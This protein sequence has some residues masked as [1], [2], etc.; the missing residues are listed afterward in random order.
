M[1]GTRKRPE[2]DLPISIAINKTPDLQ[3]LFYCCHRILFRVTTVSS[4]EQVMEPGKLIQVPFLKV[5][6]DLQFRS[7]SAVTN[8]FRLYSSTQCVPRV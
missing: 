5:I 8:L 7:S 3:E 6:A 1:V 4:F 2:I